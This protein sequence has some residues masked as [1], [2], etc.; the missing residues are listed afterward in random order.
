MIMNWVMLLSCFEQSIWQGNMKLDKEEKW[1]F[2]KV[3]VANFGRNKQRHKA[4]Q[5]EYVCVSF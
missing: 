3:C 1:Y 5:G 2:S 4:N